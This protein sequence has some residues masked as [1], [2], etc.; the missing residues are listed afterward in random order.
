MRS[1]SSPQLTTQVSTAP[2][3]TWQ[4]DLSRNH[5]PTTDDVDRGAYD[6]N[7]A[8]VFPLDQIA[9]AHR[10]M[11]SDAVAGKIVVVVYAGV[12]SAMAP[13]TAGATTISV[14]SSYSAGLMRERSVRMNNA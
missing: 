9:E 4:N 12:I 1:A 10:T 7:V 13:G 3:T 8:R 6:A 11:E 14:M 2:N 5:P